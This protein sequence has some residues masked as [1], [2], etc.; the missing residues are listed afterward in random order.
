MSA[1]TKHPAGS[2]K[3]A[4]AGYPAWLEVVKQQV[5]SLRFGTVQITVHDGRVVQVERLE[6]IRIQEEP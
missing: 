1:T 4:A 2:S 6:K 5:A 3:E